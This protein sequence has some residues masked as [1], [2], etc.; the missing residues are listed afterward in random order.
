[1][2]IAIQLGQKPNGA[3]SVFTPKDEFWLWQTAKTYVQSADGQYQEAISHLLR[4]HM[5]L[6]TIAVSTHRQL[7][8]GH[9]VH[10][11]LIPHF[12]FTMAI[13][14][15]ARNKLLAHDGPIDNVFAMGVDG[16]FDL[17]EKVWKHSWTF[18]DYDLE[19]DLKN[20]GVDDPEQLPGYHYRDDARK[21]ESAIH[22][23]VGSVVRHFYKS[24]E[25]VAADFELQSWTRELADPTEGNLRGFPTEL[26]SVDQVISL[27]TTIIFTASGGHS[28]TNNGQYEM[29]GYIPNVPGAMYAPPPTRKDSCSEQ[30]LADALPKG[31]FAGQQ[32]ATAH[33]LSEPTE[34]PLGNYRPAFFAG[35]REVEPMMKQF[36]R[37]LF[38]ISQSNEARNEALE[39][40][41]TYLDPKRIYPSVEI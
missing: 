24:N 27:L 26:G 17:I 33:L 16:G 37:Q 36:Q 6:E 8:I 14:H 18:D 7:G 15:A 32:I 34:D 30:T 25:D 41:Y 35:H 31:K 29:Y 21:L 5:V 23:F 28:S 39:V 4:T 38:E 11:L 2:P 20:R 3:E 10:K 1:M 13:N 12:R 40:P 22:E 9:P 19:K